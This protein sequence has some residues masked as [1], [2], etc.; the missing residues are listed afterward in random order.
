MD[1]LHKALEIGLKK[2]PEIFLKR[3]IL[4]KLE[5]QGVSDTSELVDALFN[6]IM[7]GDDENFSWDDGVHSPSGDQNVELI[8]SDKDIADWRESLSSFWTVE[9]PVLIE[10]TSNQSAKDV[11]HNLKNSWSEVDDYEVAINADFKDRLEDRWGMALD[12]L[13]RANRYFW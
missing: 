3:M 9:L 12:L 1:S 10:K 4:S 13:R 6:H 5:E 7:S 11:L 8:F 2:V